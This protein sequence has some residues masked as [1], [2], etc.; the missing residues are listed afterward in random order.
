MKDDICWFSF[1]L[2]FGM[3]GRARSNFMGPNVYYL[4]AVSPKVGIAYI[5][6]ALELGGLPLCAAHYDE[7]S[8]SPTGDQS[9]RT[10]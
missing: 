10:Q 4:H 6:V 7:P 2:W 3:G 8:P 1:F 5:L 9:L